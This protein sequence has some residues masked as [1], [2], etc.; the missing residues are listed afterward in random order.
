MHKIKLLRGCTYLLLLQQGL[1]YADIS[2]KVFTDFNLNGV[3]DST[4]SI[5]N[6]AKNMSINTALDQ[7]LS[8]VSVQA[9]CVTSSGS[10]NL[11]PPQ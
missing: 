8:G 11:T 3:L 10:T 4:G 2:G 1:A 5:Q 9:S 7:G 6:F